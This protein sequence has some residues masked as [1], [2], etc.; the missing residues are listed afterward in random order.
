[1][2]KDLN[3][4]L[5]LLCGC[6]CAGFL[7]SGCGAPPR[8]PKPKV[9]PTLS[10]PEDVKPRATT[11]GISYDQLMQDLSAHF[12]MTQVEKLNPREADQLL[13]YT[14]EQ[15][16]TRATLILQ[17][18]KADLLSASFYAAIPLA[19]KDEMEKPHVKRNLELQA[20]FLNNL[21]QKQVPAEFEEEMKKAVEFPNV[22]RHLRRGRIDL[23]IKYES[24]EKQV[25]LQAKV[26]RE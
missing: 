22:N 26:N 24:A 14:E 23:A 8:P 13:G 15:V 7:L 17:G 12:S 10:L 2:E 4:R 18:R 6:L 11:L 9:D 16:A 19:H 5:G 21:Y 1:M 3:M 25:C 20:V